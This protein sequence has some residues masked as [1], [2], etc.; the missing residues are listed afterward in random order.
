MSADVLWKPS[1]VGFNF[2]SL[3]QPV[4]VPQRVMAAPNSGS[5]THKMNQLQFNLGVPTTA[6][7]FTT[8]FR[9]PQPIVIE[10]LGDQNQTPQLLPQR[11]ATTPVV[12][13]VVP[14]VS[15]SITSDRLALA[16]HLAK[17]D[18]RKVK[19]IGTE[20]VLVSQEEETK[21][22]H[23]A[24]TGKNMGVGKKNRVKSMKSKS[25]AAMSEDKP[26]LRE[27]VHIAVKKQEAEARKQRKMY[28]YPAARED[29][30]FESDGERT[31][32]NEIRKLRKE[33][34]QYMKQMESLK[35]ERPEMLKNKDKRLKKRK[36]GEGR[37][38]DEEVDKRQVVRAE[39]QAA[40]SARMLYV[41][42]R[43]VREIE[44]EL[45]KKKRGIKHTKKSQ[46]LSRLAAA[47][48]GAVRALQTFVSQAPLQPKVGHGSPPM[49]QELS[50]LIRQLSLLAAQQRW[51]DE[52]AERRIRD[53][54]RERRLEVMQRHR[55]SP[56]VSL[57]KR[58]ICETEDAIRSRLKPLLDR[59]EA[60]AETQAI[61]EEEQKKSLQHQLGKLA[62]QTTMNQ[63]DILA[64]KVLDDILEDT[65]LEMQRRV[66]GSFLTFLSLRSLTL[67]EIE[68]DVE[69]QA[70]DLQNSSSLDNILQRLQ[71]FEKAEEEIRQHWVQVNYADVENSTEKHHTEKRTRPAKDPK[72]IMF[73]RPVE[74]ESHRLLPENTRA[75]PDDDGRGVRKP[76]RLLNEI[77]AAS[78]FSSLMEASTERSSAQS[79]IYK[80]PQNSSAPQSWPLTSGTRPTVFLSVPKEMKAS[81]VSYR[82]RFNKYL[83]DTSTHEE[84]TFDPWG[85]VN[86]I[87]EELL[88]DALQEVGH[89][90]DD[91]CDDYAEALYN[92]EFVSVSSDT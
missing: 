2:P 30:E 55:R 45:N 4:S 54:E 86:R 5:A 1:Q 22:R 77:S 82:N 6:D 17:K 31:Q 34:H 29:D 14:S 20:N 72:P 74:T 58:L 56:D 43:Q 3:N 16:V 69:M 39:E 9:K 66:S 41:L 51:L 81:I 75:P 68:D 13:P 63:A 26:T 12:Y 33:L 59:A 53:L 37:L 89:E 11:H 23:F 79:S 10:K 60:I 85:L 52:E 90:L 32:A 46:T 57:P 49:Y 48:R 88:E 19:E 91:V 18:V 87:S 36:E 35:D 70:D 84:G 7:Q 38:A 64:E 28:F 61:R 21:R 42:Q 71:S 76:F 24:V 80:S 47:H 27:R 92:Q 50:A 83:Q 78:S 67:L 15:S 40:R 25:Q 73:T 65:V 44:D 62:S 8:R